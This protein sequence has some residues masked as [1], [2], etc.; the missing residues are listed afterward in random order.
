MGYCFE[1]RAEHGIDVN[2]GDY[3]ATAVLKNGVVLENST[4]LDEF[5]FSA[6][7]L[8][9]KRVA[10]FGRNKKYS[11]AD[12]PAGLSPLEALPSEAVPVSQE[13]LD[14]LS[15]QV[16]TNVFLDQG[17]FSHYLAL[18]IVEDGT[19]VR[20]IPLNAANVKINWQSRGNYIIQVS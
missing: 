14:S 16:S 1:I 6:L 4:G 20:E 17:L 11:L 8:P 2:P 9:G 15:F 7:L 18:G 13:Q 10:G 5:G 3:F 12:L 19:L